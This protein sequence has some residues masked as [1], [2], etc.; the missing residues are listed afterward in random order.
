MFFVIVGIV[1]LF[2]SFII[3]LFSLVREQDG[4]EESYLAPAGKDKS[5]SEPAAEQEVLALEPVLAE[6]DEN[7][8]QQ[9]EGAA[10][11]VSERVEPFPWEVDDGD[12]DDSGQTVESTNEI[13]DKAGGQGRG[14]LSGEIS[15]K[16]LRKKMD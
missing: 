8:A 3:A 13:I 16:D 15:V 7:H 6:S 12:I 14:I 4:R 2:V 9:Q 5:D 10:G 1:I 11:A